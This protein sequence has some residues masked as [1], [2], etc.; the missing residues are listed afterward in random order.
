MSP[1]GDRILASTVYLDTVLGLDFDP[2]PGEVRVAGVTKND[3]G[4]VGY[5]AAYAPDDRLRFAIQ[6]GDTS[7][8]HNAVR[9]H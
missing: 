4:T 8:V 7:R 9:A 6:I 2:G 5:V 3:N 1:A